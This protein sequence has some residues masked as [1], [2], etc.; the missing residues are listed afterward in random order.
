MTGVGITDLQIDNGEGD[1]R[2]WY[3]AVG[4]FNPT[5]AVASTPEPATCGLA[6]IGLGL[7]GLMRKRLGPK[8]L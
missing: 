6:V 8:F 5:G 3:Y 7:L 4:A 1:S 2:S